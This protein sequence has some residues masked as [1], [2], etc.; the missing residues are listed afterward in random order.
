MTS[1]FALPCVSILDSQRPTG[2]DVQN[3]TNDLV[4]EI[5]AAHE[6]LDPARQQLLEQEA[7]RLLQEQDTSHHHRREIQ[8]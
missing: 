4:A 6:A 5:A 2:E 1:A 7:A 3:P 8:S